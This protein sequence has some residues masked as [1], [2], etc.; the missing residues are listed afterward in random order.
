[1]RSV[2]NLQHP[3]EYAV[4][5]IFGGRPLITNIIRWASYVPGLDAYEMQFKLSLPWPNG[6]RAS[7]S[8]TEVWE[9]I[10]SAKQAPEPDAA[11][12][13]ALLDEAMHYFN[14]DKNIPCCVVPPEIK[15]GFDKTP[16]A[17][18]IEWAAKNKDLPAVIRLTAL[19]HYVKN[20]LGAE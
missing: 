20:K 12:L 11:Q 4:M 18:M 5:V 8:S 3:Q 15:L 13:A 9:G 14:N 19:K 2:L 6:P 10:L 17:P 7:H 16:T 1:M